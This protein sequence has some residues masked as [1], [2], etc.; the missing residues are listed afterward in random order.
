MSNKSWFKKFFRHIQMMR[1]MTLVYMLIGT[2]LAIL[3][4]GVLLKGYGG[5][6]I[7]LVSASL[8]GFFVG[9]SGLIIVIRREMNLGIISFEGFAAVL[10]GGTMV[11]SG[12]IMSA[13]FF[14]AALRALGLIQ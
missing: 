5:D 2:G 9:L 14:M 4:L 12:F 13:G 7:I 1:T 10:Y 3:I 6:I 8:F 11:L